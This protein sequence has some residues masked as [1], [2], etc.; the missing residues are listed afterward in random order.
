MPECIDCRHCDMKSE[1]AQARAGSGNCSFDSMV[2]QFKNVTW[3]RDCEKFDALP[4]EQSK[5]RREW[6]KGK[7]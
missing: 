1:K 3:P 5:A 7:R 4:T 2:G 6:L